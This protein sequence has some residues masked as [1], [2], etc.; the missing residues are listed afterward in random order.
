MIRI[1]MTVTTSVLD[2]ELVLLDQATG[3]YFGLNPVAS[4]MFQL[5]R[6]TGDIRRTGDALQREY[7]A[8][9]ERLDSD[10][11]TFMDALIQKGIVSI[12]AS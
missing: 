3:K 9:R 2:D 1:P 4:R 6:E 8:P 5:L 10:L 7:D 12:D 11:K